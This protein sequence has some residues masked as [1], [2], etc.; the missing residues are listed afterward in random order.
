MTSSATSLSKGPTVATLTAIEKVLREESLPMSRYKIRQA[1]G[2]RVGAPALDEAL[3]YMA[4]HEMVYDEGPGGK[5]V[6][7]R[8][9]LA[10]LTKLRGA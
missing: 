3:S 2:N 6:W 7:I 9:P 1:L 5:V 8:A 4:A 10:T